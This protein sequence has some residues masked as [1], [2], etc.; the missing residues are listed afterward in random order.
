MVR[1]KQLKPAPER[2][3]LAGHEDFVHAKNSHPLPD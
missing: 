1:L 3:H 2:G